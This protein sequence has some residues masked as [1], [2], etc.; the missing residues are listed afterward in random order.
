MTGAGG[1]QS[2]VS[3][4]WCLLLFPAA[5]AGNTVSFSAGSE[6]HDTRLPSED[7]GDHVVLF[8]LLNSN[9]KG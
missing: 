9:I 7:T 2:C 4:S 5:D 1:R 8:L 3:L 6:D